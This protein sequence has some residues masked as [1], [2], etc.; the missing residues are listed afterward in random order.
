MLWEKLL[1]H[2]SVHSVLWSLLHQTTNST[3]S[4]LTPPSLHFLHEFSASST[5]LSFQD[6]YPGKWPLCSMAFP[7]AAELLLNPS[8]LQCPA[9]SPLHQGTLGGEGGTV[10]FTNSWPLLRRGLGWGLLKSGL[11][12]RKGW[13]NLRASC[14]EISLCAAVSASAAF[15][16]LLHSPNPS[17]HDSSKGTARSICVTMET[18]WRQQIRGKK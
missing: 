15:C 10:L 17:L 14:D 2:S 11:L 16:W 6:L 3:F 7:M 13:W 4:L 9:S 1:N 8:C 5:Q 18:K 12:E